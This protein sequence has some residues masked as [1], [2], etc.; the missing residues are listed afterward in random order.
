MAVASPS[1][2]SSS[3]PAQ[4]AVEEEEKETLASNEVTVVGAGPAGCLLAIYLLRRGFSVNLFEKREATIAGS[5]MP[6]LA[7]FV[8]S[9]GG[10]GVCA[11][12]S[13]NCTYHQHI[14]LVF[15]GRNR[16][17]KNHSRKTMNASTDMG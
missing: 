2:S 14:Y 9:P 1:S 15:C 7:D 17:C 16:N 6:L 12:L 3:T 5:G 11:S 13:V 4:Q 10:D 8:P